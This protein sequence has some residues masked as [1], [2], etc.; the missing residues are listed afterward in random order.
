MAETRIDVQ[1]EHRHA[2]PPTTEA[3]EHVP[4]VRLALP[5]RRARGRA[6]GLR[7]VRPP[8]P[9][10]GRARIDGSPTRGRSS[11]RR[12]TSARTTRSSSSTCGRTPSGWP[13]PS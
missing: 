12:P 7:P 10:A 8:L 1:V 5:R 9:D 2:P 3:S 11:R 6:L 4:E 13:R